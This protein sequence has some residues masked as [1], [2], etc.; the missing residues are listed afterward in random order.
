MM[1]LPDITNSQPMLT[2]NLLIKLTCLG[3]VASYLQQF[4]VT[5]IR[6]LIL[7]VSRLIFII[8]QIRELKI[9]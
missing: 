2:G 1:A 5:R 8:K 7:G 3:V 4:F 9:A 6:L